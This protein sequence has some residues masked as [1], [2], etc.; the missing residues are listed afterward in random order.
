MDD[1]T[2]TDKQDEAQSNEDSEWGSPVRI[3]KGTRRRL[4]GLV[5]LMTAYP[6]IACLP[7][8]VQQVFREAFAISRNAFS[9]DVLIDTAV[10]S[11]KHVL[12]APPP[13]PSATRKQV[14]S[15][16]PMKARRR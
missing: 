15:S 7:A 11:L 8:D 10:A 5:S 2:T 9:P 14:R 3:R 4:E 16:S 13:E 1:N 12:T 6:G